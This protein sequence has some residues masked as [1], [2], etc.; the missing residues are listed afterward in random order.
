MNQASIVTMKMKV[1]GMEACTI[2][3]SNFMTEGL[4]FVLE[5]CVIG[6]VLY[7]SLHLF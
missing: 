5:E 2:N 6:T 3:D 1:A 7:W 4:G